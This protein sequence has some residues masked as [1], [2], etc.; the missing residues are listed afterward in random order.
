[1]ST[2]AGVNANF[3]TA[4]DQGGANKVVYDGTGSG[5]GVVTVTGLTAGTLYF[6]TVVEYNEGTGT[7]QNYL[8]SP[9]VTASTST[10]GLPSPAITVNLTGFTGLF[11]NV[12]M[13]ANS[14]AQ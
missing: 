13:G 3:T 2:M 1:A 6:F 5:A 12:V 7:S 10:A 11:G 8:L 14:T 4:T 9:V